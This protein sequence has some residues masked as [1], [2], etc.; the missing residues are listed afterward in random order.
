MDDGQIQN[1][2][3]GQHNLVRLGEVDFGVV[4]HVENALRGGKVVRA[5][6]LLGNEARQLRQVV[7]QKVAD[8]ERVNRRERGVDH[9]RGAALVVRADAGFQRFVHRGDDL[10]FPIVGDF[11]EQK[12]LAAEEFIERGFGN[13]R[14]RRQHIQR[15]FFNPGADGVFARAFLQPFADGVALLGGEGLRHGR[16]S[17]V[18][19]SR[20]FR[21]FR[22]CFTDYLLIVTVPFMPGSSALP[23]GRVMRTSK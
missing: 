13:P 20:G 11:K 7:A 3:R 8:A 4:E 17:F 12:L 1:L 16:A 5:R 19:S 9:V 15:G 21:P 18:L 22:V 14:V 23:L 2:N 6:F 10:H